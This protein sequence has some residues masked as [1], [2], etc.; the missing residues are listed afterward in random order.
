M[1]I[2]ITEQQKQ[3]IK[4]QHNLNGDVG[5]KLIDVILG[6]DMVYKIFGVDDEDAYR[7]GYHHKGALNGN[8]N[9]D[10]FYRA[11]KMFYYPKDELLY[12]HYS[13]LPEVNKYLPTS[14]D[15]ILIYLKE[16]F[17]SYYDHLVKGVFLY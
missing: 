13:I 4:S 6:H 9:V 1:R 10:D 11:A 14:K 8:E 3:D 15:K 2:I 5:V 17:E 12:V 7:Y 16:W